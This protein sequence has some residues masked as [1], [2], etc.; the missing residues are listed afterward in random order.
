MSSK[1]DIQRNKL[2]HLKDTLVMYGVYNTETL[3]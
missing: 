3:E 1:A 2:M